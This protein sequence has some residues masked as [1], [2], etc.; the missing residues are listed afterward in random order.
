M[1]TDNKTIDTDGIEAVG[2]KQ[3]RQRKV[4]SPSANQSRASRPR[5]RVP[6]S[7]YRDILTVYGKDPDYEYRWVKDSV[8]TGQ[9]ILRFLAAGY[10][11]VQVDEIESV[12][13]NMVF[14]TEGEG[15]IIRTPAGDHSSG[16]YMY[17][18]KQLKDYYEEDQKDKQDI[19]SAREAEANR[20]RN[21]DLDDGMYGEG[22][23][24]TSLR[25]PVVV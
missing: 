15:S 12:G 19:I 1:A 6:V 18:M 24:S 3:T 2:K 13:T 25:R 14:K 8:E 10:V 23:L 5:K 17:L 22:K 16:E 21:E 7:G 9:R 4:E 11:F 20:K